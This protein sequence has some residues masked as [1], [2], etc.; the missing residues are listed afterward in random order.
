MFY[1]HEKGKISYFQVSQSN[2]ATY[3]RCG[4]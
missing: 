3:L 1:V 2:V 4:G